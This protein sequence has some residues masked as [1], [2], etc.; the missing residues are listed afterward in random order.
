MSAFTNHR[1][2]LVVGQ[3]LKELRLAAGL[4][5]ADIAFLLSSTVGQ[6]DLYERGG[7][8]IG[9][10]RL[11]ELADCFGVAVWTF[12]ERLGQNSQASAASRRPK[13]PRGNRQR[14]ERVTTLVRK[15]MRQTTNRIAD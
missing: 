4:T 10:G 5:Q 13:G 14:D 12:F 6:I 3:R 7:A 11:A 2:D 1:T 15:I 9:I 8:R